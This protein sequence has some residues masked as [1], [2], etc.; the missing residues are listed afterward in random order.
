MADDKD[1]H[2]GKWIDGFKK[3]ITAL[4]G[5][6]SINFVTVLIYLD[7]ID[8]THKVELYAL[9]IGSISALAAGHFYVQ[10]K[11]DKPKV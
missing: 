2:V 4:T 11:L 9:C 10:S 8:G 3:L 6:L 7:S 1:T 5:I